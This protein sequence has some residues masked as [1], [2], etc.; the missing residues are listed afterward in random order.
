MCFGE[1]S[2]FLLKLLKRNVLKHH[3]FIDAGF[4]AGW[5]NFGGH[6][7]TPHL[8]PH[9]QRWNTCTYMHEFTYKMND[10]NWYDIEVYTLLHEA[11]KASGNRHRHQY[12]ISV[13]WLCS[14]S[15][16][17]VIPSNHWYMPHLSRWW[18][19]FSLRC[20]WSIA[21]RCCSYYIFILDLTPGFKGLDRNDCKTRPETFK[22]WDLVWLILEIRR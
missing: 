2:G 5:T 1:R 9:F 18:N 12:H 11:S 6:S 8:Q 15:C 14:Y 22:F 13:F 21:C 16:I 10:R 4:D 7:S 17:Y 3:L 20:S 19:C